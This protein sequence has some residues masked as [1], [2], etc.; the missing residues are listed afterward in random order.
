M[1]PRMRRRRRMGNMP[2]SKQFTPSNT[3]CQNPPVQMLHEEYETL[4]LCDYENLTHEQAC[5]Q[6]NVSR[7]TFTRMYAIARQKMACAL[8]ESRVL[9]IEGGNVFYEES[10]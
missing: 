10:Q 1:S 2:Q 7:P 8:V 3:S 6:M 9:V 4:R 5:V